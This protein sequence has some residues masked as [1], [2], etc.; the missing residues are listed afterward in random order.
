MIASWG[1]LGQLMPILAKAIIGHFCLQDK[2]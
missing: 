2:K 1:F